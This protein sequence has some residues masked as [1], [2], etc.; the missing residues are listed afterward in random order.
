MRLNLQR[1]EN[2]RDALAMARRGGL[3]CIVDPSELRKAGGKYCKG[4]HI[5]YSRK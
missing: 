5:L 3:T 2:S 4:L 1:L